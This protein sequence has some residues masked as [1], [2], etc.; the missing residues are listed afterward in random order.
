MGMR[1]F[2]RLL[3]VLGT[4]TV[5]FGLAKLHAVRHHYVL[6]GS[7]RFSWAVAYVG[8]VCVAA[9][10]AG[11]P[12]VPRRRSR[13]LAALVATG[14][15]AGAISL[16]QLFAGDALLPRF[17]V[18]GSAVVLVP[19]FVLCAGIAD[20]GRSRAEDRDRVV[21][22]GDLDEGDTLRLELE[23]APERPAAIVAALD[24]G[25]AVGRDKG[26]EPLVDLAIAKRATVVVLSRTAQDD[27]RIVDQAAVL[28]AAGLR[29]R[30]LA[31]FY[32]DW[33][34]K[35]PIGELERVSLLFDIGEIHGRGYARVKRLLD[36][37]LGG[38]GLVVL[39]L[40]TPLVMLGDLVA[41]RG[42]LLYRQPRV[43]RDGR[44]F[45]VLKFR[46]MRAGEA[47][48]G[49][50][51]TCEEDPR[52]APFGRLLRRLHLDELPQMVNIVR[53]E[54]SLVGPRPEQPHY[55]EE[56]EEKI[57]FYGLRHLV[58]PGLTGWAQVKFGY[59]S[60]AHDALEKLQYDFFYLRRQGLALDARIL[61]RTLRD[62]VDRGGR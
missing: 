28:H 1:R 47:A 32:E 31:G 3:V 35:L 14:L 59:A 21:L 50:E 10:A 40:I 23:A 9:Y 51:W 26:T 19:W 39:A 4:I 58:R 22:V 45:T 62:V 7:S 52:V 54:L 33:L 20:G 24:A 2:A 6:H 49:G 43:G 53:G 25:S 13:V 17:V 57:P 30:S 18:F 61:G 27:E 38:V 8:L 44:V 42:A 36:L 41:N 56:L 60:D 15:G 12:E 5:V 34:G 48:L 37:A 55:V 46:T 11:L 29:V 16:V